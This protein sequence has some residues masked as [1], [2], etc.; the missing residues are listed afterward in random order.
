MIVANAPCCKHCHNM[1]TC[2][3]VA[4][5]APATD[6]FGQPVLKASLTAWWN[7]LTDACVPQGDADL[8]SDI[9]GL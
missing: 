9:P 8:G 6:Q 7:P 3:N 5:P 2:L 1:L 4:H